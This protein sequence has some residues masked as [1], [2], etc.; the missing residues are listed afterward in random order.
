MLDPKKI[1]KMSKNLQAGVE[2]VKEELARMTVEGVS[3][4]GALRVVVN[5]NQDFVKV[6]IKPEAVDPDDIAMLEDL[7]L[8]AA[9]QAMEKAKEL[10]QKSIGQLT[11]GMNIPGLF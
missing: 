5:G 2:T 9:N 6:S 8:A 10:Q 4:G 7:F 11:G 1:Q 3:G